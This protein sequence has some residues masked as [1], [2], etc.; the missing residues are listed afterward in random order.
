MASA[1]ASIPGLVVDA[2][3]NRIEITKLVPG[4][5]LKRDVILIMFD[6]G[7]V[8]IETRL[9]SGSKVTLREGVTDSDDE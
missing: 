1:K 8:T 7:S 3:D 2:S 5:L 9:D 6:A 4:S